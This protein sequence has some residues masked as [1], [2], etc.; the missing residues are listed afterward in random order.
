MLH[1]KT[2]VSDTPASVSILLLDN[3]DTL[4]PRSMFSDGTFVVQTRTPFPWEGGPID[5][6]RGVKSSLGMSTTPAT[7]AATATATTTTPTSVEIHHHH[8]N[9]GVATRVH[10]DE[11]V[12]PKHHDSGNIWQTLIGNAT[13]DRRG[14]PTSCNS[15]GEC[16]SRFLLTGDDSAA[17]DS[18]SSSSSDSDIHRHSHHAGCLA[19]TMGETYGA[20]LTRMEHH[21]T[22]PPAEWAHAPNDWFSPSS[23]PPPLR[24]NQR[25][26]RHGARDSSSTMPMLVC[27]QG[28]V[29]C[30]CCLLLH[31]CA[32]ASSSSSS[33][34][35]PSSDTTQQQQQQEEPQFGRLT[36]PT[37]GCSFGFSLS[38]F[39]HFIYAPETL[40]IAFKLFDRFESLARD[41]DRDAK[42]VDVWGRD[43]LAGECEGDVDQQNRFCC[44]L[45]DP[46][47]P[48]TIDA[49]TNCDCRFIRHML[50]T[51]MITAMTTDGFAGFA[52]A[53]SFLPTTAVATATATS[54]YTCDEG[55]QGAADSRYVFCQW[56]SEDL[57]WL[58]HEWF[59]SAYTSEREWKRQCGSPDMF[60]WLT[61]QYDLEL[62][63]ENGVAGRDEQQQ[64]QQQWRRRRRSSSV[65]MAMEIG[66]LADLV[67]DV[68]TTNTNA[69]ANVD[70]VAEQ[71]ET[72]NNGD[73]DAD[74]T[75]KWRVFEEARQR[76]LVDMA[77]AMVE[78]RSR[79]AQER[80][81]LIAIS[82][83]R[84]VDQH[85]RQQQQRILT[86]WL[87]VGSTWKWIE[88]S[89]T[90][91]LASEITSVLFRMR[92]WQLNDIA[93]RL[94]PPFAPRCGG[95]GGGGG[96]NEGEG[97]GDLSRCYQRFALLFHLAVR[98]A[99]V[100]KWIERMSS[101]CHCCGYR[102]PSSG[103]SHCKVCRMWRCSECMSMAVFLP[104]S[105][106]TARAEK[107][108]KK[109]AK[110]AG[111]AEEHQKKEKGDEM[112]F[113]GD[114]IAVANQMDVDDAEGDDKC[115]ITISLPTPVCRHEEEKED[116]DDDDDVGDDG[117][118]DLYL[119]QLIR[120]L[121]DGVP[122]TS[123]QFCVRLPHSPSK[124]TS[125]RN[126]PPYGETHTAVSPRARAM[127]TA[128]D[129]ILA[130]VK[131][132]L[133]SISATATTTSGMGAPLSDN[134]RVLCN[135]Q[136]SLFRE[137][138]GLMLE[139]AN[140]PLHVSRP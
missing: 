127:Q 111:N 80:L 28:H 13:A 103:R 37:Q 42:H 46:M 125:I 63:N 49:M 59:P 18:S 135:W 117:G 27:F 11:V 105:S 140:C 124:C 130:R 29:H 26:H 48:S 35:H 30:A 107:K 2:L 15:G 38:K 55:G 110:E 133:E 70:D 45:G 82:Y 24:Y 139:N 112:T 51:P 73:D 66:P 128:M 120:A 84:H 83:L 93:E 97:S 122:V 108:K 87:R 21:H 19:T 106:T 5:V 126:G 81:D 89:T 94:P 1:A 53:P 36:C 123:L 16:L 14:M 86:K 64:Q 6:T 132:M 77:R 116:E 3:V 61:I 76:R 32:V 88:H 57:K 72:D 85:T 12:V 39:W 44:P 90:P 91:T 119:T 79:W 131:S 8:L 40:S 118:D 31:W 60:T 43:A 71:H 121:N 7:A 10:P 34:H 114:C 4:I 100:A 41:F 52:R 20:M 115:A 65:G 99:H 78:A 102:D 95:G 68:A 54:H 58:L 22:T 69:N 101:A 67:F 50:H 47:P 25:D 23:C 134:V 129:T 138:V 104:L 92:P 74:T 136:W 109:K 75:I 113:D 17:N 9:V 62:E 98:V 137:C 56:R 33:H 96:G